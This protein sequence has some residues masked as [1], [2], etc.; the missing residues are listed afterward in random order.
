MV[1]INQ[2]KKTFFLLYSSILN[3][4]FSKQQWFNYYIEKYLLP[5]IRFY[6]LGYF[7]NDFEPEV[8]TSNPY[9][10]TGKGRFDFL[11]GDVAVEF[12]VRTPDCRSTK[13]KRCDN[14]DEIAKLAK[15]SG[16]SVLVLFDF[17]KKIL[18]ESALKAE[19]GELPSLGQGVKRHPFSLL[20]YFKD[21]E[22]NP[23]VIRK[24]IR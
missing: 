8:A 13:L 1:T 3:E 20:Y 22:G 12:A 15:Y 2:I 23:K 11:V 14:E 24:N 19:Y 5:C 9:S 16:D 18:T 10:Y 6:L 7:A 4:R 21:S 17:S